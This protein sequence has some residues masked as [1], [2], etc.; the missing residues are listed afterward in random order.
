MPDEGV[1]FRADVV[2][3]AEV[4]ERISGWAAV[5]VRTIL[6]ESGLALD[7]FKVGP[8]EGHNG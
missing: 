8:I 3:L 1:S 6:G 7:G 2:R 5:E 4:E